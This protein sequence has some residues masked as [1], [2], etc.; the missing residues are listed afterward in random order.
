MARAAVKQLD[1]AAAK[2]SLLSNSDIKKTRARCAVEAQRLAEQIDTIAGRHASDLLDVFHEGTIALNVVIQRCGKLTALCKTGD[3]S[4]VVLPDTF[5]SVV[6]SY[7][8]KLKSKDLAAFRPSDLYVLRE[9][10]G[11]I[12]KR[13][14]ADEHTTR[15]E[16]SL[17]EWSQKLDDAMALVARDKRE[18]ASFDQ[19]Y[20]VVKGTLKKKKA[21]FRGYEAFYDKLKGDLKAAKQQS[22]T[23]D[24][25]RSADATIRVAKAAMERVIVASTEEGRERGL[26]LDQELRHGQESATAGTER[27]K[28][29]KAAWEARVTVFRSRW[30][31]LLPLDEKDARGLLSIAEKSAGQ[32]P[33]DYEAANRYLKMAAD[34]A[35]LALQFPGGP[36]AVSLS[37]LPKQGQDWTGA[38]A[39]YRGSFESLGGAFGELD[40]PAGAALAAGIAALKLLF[41]PNAFATII[42][43]ICAK[44]AGVDERARAREEALAVV[45]RYRS[46][47][48]KDGRF[49]LLSKHPFSDAGAWKGHLI[50]QQPLIELERLLLMAVPT[51]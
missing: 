32:K 39:S 17:E 19:L 29:Q 24:G 6:K 25:I 27:Q 44:G 4:E 31:R 50:I 15:I 21:L 11:A 51:T 35:Q 20:E 23:E 30:L 36:V 3:E 28:D 45:R 33:P 9:D 34:R 41:D 16:A 7:H 13:L 49:N 47:L 12:E 1:K 46:V 26:T 22:E 42:P 40:D 5:A 48:V 43:R 10:L 18:K 2:R 38:V 8:T 37:K 14:G